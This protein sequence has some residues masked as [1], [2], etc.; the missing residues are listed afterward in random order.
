MTIISHWRMITVPRNELWNMDPVNL[1]RFADAWVSIG[2]EGRHAVLDIM[3]GAGEDAPYD[4]VWMARMRLSE[5]NRSI[6]RAIEAW[7]ER[8]DR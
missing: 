7:M 5:Y 8:K 3:C 1:L 6:D 2:D 4:I